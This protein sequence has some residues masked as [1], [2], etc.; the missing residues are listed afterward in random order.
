MC[1]CSDQSLQ[2]RKCEKI[3]AQINLCLDKGKELTPDINIFNDDSFKG[4]RFTN[5]PGQNLCYLNAAINALINCKSVRILVN[6]DL[7]CEI[8]NTFK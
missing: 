5:H 3:F 1:N 7:Q 4:I 6:S 8:I 2:C